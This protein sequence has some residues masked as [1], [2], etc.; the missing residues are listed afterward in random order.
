VFQWID[1]HQKAFEQVKYILTNPEGPILA[2]FDPQ[3]PTTLLT[4]ASRLKGIGFALIQT[5]EQGHTK[6]IQCGSRFLSDTET[7]Y[8]VC[9]L[10]SLAIQWAI[11]K[12]R[13]YLQGISFHIITDHRPLISI[14]RGTN[15]DAIE[16][17]RIQ[18]IL[19]KIAGYTFTIEWVPGKT[20]Y[21]A[22]AFS[23]SPV[24]D[25]EEADITDEGIISVN[26]ISVNTDLALD[27]FIVA[28]GNDASYQAILSALRQDADVKK[29]PET[30]PGR[31]L[32]KQWP[33]LSIDATGLVLLHNQRIL[34]PQSCRAKVLSE[35]H[36]SHQGLRK[37]KERAKFLYF[38]PGITNDINQIVSSCPQCLEHS[39]S[40]PDQPL[41]QSTSSRPFEHVSVDLFEVAGKHYIVLVDRYT[42]WPLVAHLRKTDT[43][44]VTNILLDWFQDYGI[45]VTIRSDSGPQF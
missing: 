45:P 35:L 8:A 30:H 36:L 9:E 40:Q 21:I 41:Q 28:A 18:R 6:L 14:F 37:T 12:C 39:P 44:A 25:P 13:L 7:R 10:E 5:S 20:H 3:L 19:Q 16:N 4:D 33:H 24:F 15:L 2:H 29:L 1:D 32:A 42:G 17:T 31:L 22:D 26:V 34:V 38:W 11:Q 27:S 43:R 23:R